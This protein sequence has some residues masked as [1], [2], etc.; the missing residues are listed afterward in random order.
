MVLKHDL[1]VHTDEPATTKELKFYM[2]KL[3]DAVTTKYKMLRSAFR[4]I[5]ED[6]SGHLT[7]EEIVN[8]VQH[9]ALPIPLTH[10]HEIFAGMDADGNGKVSYQEFADR[11]QGFDDKWIHTEERMRAE[12]LA[13][14]GK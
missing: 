11:I 14:A 7:T 6:A 9:F 8:A 13:K 10:I 1:G 3:R 5:D 4:S 12:A 2:G